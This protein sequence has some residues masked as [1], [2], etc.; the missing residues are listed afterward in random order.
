MNGSETIWVRYTWD[1]QDF[2]PVLSI[3]AGYKSAILSL[4]IESFSVTSPH[5][6]KLPT[7]TTEA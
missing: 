7:T 1:L 6:E 4:E 2:N 3:P 5:G